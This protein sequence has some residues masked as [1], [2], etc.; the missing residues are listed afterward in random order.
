MKTSASLTPSSRLHRPARASLLGLAAFGL[1]LTACLETLPEPWLIDDLRVLAVR[2]EPP[3]VQPGQ[4]VA[5]DALVVD[6]LNRPL[7]YAWYACIAPDLGTGFF[8]GASETSSSGGRGTGLSQDPYGD[9]C[10]LRYEAGERWAVK[11]GEA[12][13]ATLEVPV[14]LFDTQD[15]LKDA[16]GL[17]EDLVIPDDVEAFFLGIAG[18]NY[19]VTLVVEYDGGRVET[20]KRVNIALD[21]GLENNRP[22]TNPPAPVL[23]VA[24]RA[25]DIDAPTQVEAPPDGRCFSATAPLLTGKT[26]RLWP[27]N[28]QD[29]LTYLVLLAGTTS[30]EALEILENEE[31]TF[32]SFFTTKGRLDK[33]D[34]KSSAAPFNDWRIRTEDAGPADFWVVARD[35]RGGISWCHEPAVLGP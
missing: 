16:Y 27:T 25:L 17:S 29:P 34:T 1:S 15:A 22:N 31:V 24:D 13:T 4:S 9:S 32:F 3:E 7:S 33:E 11:L 12:P 26:Y 21:L 19:R 10:I 20:Q 6:P 30:G 28:I 35:G 23:H 18:L 5:L 14:D 8:S 2:A